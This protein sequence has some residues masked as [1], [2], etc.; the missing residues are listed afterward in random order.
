MLS[1]NCCV[2]TLIRIVADNIQQLSFTV[3]SIKYALPFGRTRQPT[4]RR[5]AWHSL[6]PTQ[7][8][9]RKVTDSL[10]SSNERELLS[11]P[12]KKEF[13][14]AYSRPCIVRRWRSLRDSFG[15]MVIVK[16]VIYEVITRLFCFILITSHLSFSRVPFPRHS[17]ENVCPCKR[18]STMWVQYQHWR[19]CVNLDVVNLSTGHQVS[20]IL[21]SN[22]AMFT[23]RLP[24]SLDNFKEKWIKYETMKIKFDV[25]R[26]TSF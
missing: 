4:N 26:G 16:W 11:N 7:Y 18:R 14:G 1:G 22:P 8:W 20:P 21:T 12:P 9:C 10:G 2:L 3:E 5:V 19:R 23:I 6:V 25:D 24:A 17:F 13:F 15:N